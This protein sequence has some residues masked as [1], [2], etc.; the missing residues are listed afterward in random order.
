MT[1]PGWYS[2]RAAA[3]SAEVLIHSEIGGP[4]GISAKQFATKCSDAQ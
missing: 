2:I 3:A 4:D 1:A